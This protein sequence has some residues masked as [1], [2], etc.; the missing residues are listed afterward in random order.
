MRDDKKTKRQL[1]TELEQL[2]RTVSQPLPRS[3]PEPGSETGHQQLSQIL[4]GT[5]VPTFVIDH[6]H[7]VTHWNRACANLTGIPPE[8]VIGT[9]RQW[10]AFYSEE[11]PVMADLVIEEALPAEISRYYGN[12]YRRSTV[13]DGAHEA[14]DFF[15]DIGKSGRWLFFTA[16]PLKND[17]G[18]ITGAIET[19]QDITERKQAEHALKDARDR[20]QKYLDVAGVMILVLDITQR[21]TL[22]NRRGRQILGYTEK[23]IIGENWF[24][25]CIP[26]RNRRRAKTFFNRLMTGEPERGEYFESLVITRHGEERVIAW[27]NTVLTDESGKIT[28]V[29]RSGEDLTERRLAE[30]KA[31]EAEALREVDRLRTELL[32]N[33]SHELKT[34]LT[35]IKASSS[36]LRKCDD[37][38][39]KEEKS[40]HLETIERSAASLSE[41][42]ENLLD[43]SRLESGILKMEETPV[44]MMLLMQEARSDAGVRA[45]EHTLI[46]DLPD[47][48]P[49]LTGDR[50]RIRQVLDNLID[51]ATKYSEPGTE[52]EVSACHIGNTIRVS[53]AD[54]GVGI[55]AEDLERVFERMYRVEH[56]SKE[57]AGSIGLGLAISRAIIEAHGG[58]IW[59]ESQEGEGSTCIFELPVAA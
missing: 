28:G 4:E 13:I 15:P 49:V 1:I 16:A 22:I 35:I 18:T 59:M 26:R 43:M 14:E 42:V 9:S 44:D 34:P 39:E 53:V 19:L 2:R 21:V 23:E 24:E 17:H 58:R 25:K 40:Q 51:N 57:Q 7:L 29:L 5:S 55:P 20:A 37:M 10:A 3:A 31:R 54:Q 11:R 33:V 27:H 47:A 41:L 52:V 8:E 32:A 38:L 30:E 36:M 50:R 45:P 46:W 48:L 12:N 6:Q 56:E